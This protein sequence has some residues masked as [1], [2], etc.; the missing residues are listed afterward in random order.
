MGIVDDAG[1]LEVANDPIL[2]I[3]FVTSLQLYCPQDKTADR[4]ER[5]RALSTL[6]VV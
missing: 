5:R 6:F 1:Q 3:D 2:A 4:C